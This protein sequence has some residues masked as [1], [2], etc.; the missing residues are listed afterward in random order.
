M[1]HPAPDLTGRTALVT[2]AARGIGAAIAA[3]LAAAG[4]HVVIADLLAAEGRAAAHALSSRGHQALF[5]PL[6][7]ADEWSWTEA[8]ATVVRET[9]GF[10]ILVNNAGIEVTSLIADL[11]VAAF[12]RLCEVNLMGPLLGL[13]SAFR[14]MRPS[15]AAGRGGAVVNISSTAAFTAYPASGPYAAAKAGVERLTKVAAVEAARLGYNV[16]VNCVYPGLVAT[17]LSQASA[18]RAL[19]IGLFP[20]ADTLQAY[21]LSQI[22]LGRPGVPEDVAEAVTFLASDAARYITGVGLPVAGGLGL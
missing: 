13:K 1:S 6:D 18:A 12:R 19:E 11:E 2:G 20:D 14:A 9:G 16:R 15:G 8:V 17:E 21:F 3:R 22:P 10:D 4:A 7:V 5:V